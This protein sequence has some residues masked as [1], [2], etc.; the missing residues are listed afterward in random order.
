MRISTNSI[1]DQGV[2]TI[3][4]NQAQMLKTQQQ[5]STGKR[6]LT[7]AD[8]PVGASQLITLTQSDAM[9]TQ[10]QQ[11]RQTASNSLSL[12]DNTLAQVTNILQN[13]RTI[14]VSAGNGTLNDSDRAALAAQLSGDLSELVGLANTGDGLGHYLFSGYQS[15]TQPFTQ[16][17][18]GVQYNGD[19]GQQMIQLDSSSQVAVKTSGANV[20]MN[21]PSGNGSFTTSPAGG[22]SGTGV[23][24][25]G[26]VINS[27]NLTGHKYAINFTAP[28]GVTTYNVVDTST[29]SSVQS[30]NYSSG[31]AIR[32]DGMQVTIQGAPAVGDS[33]DVS[34]STN[35]SVFT[36]VQNLIN[37]LNTPTS[38]SGGTTA[39]TNGLNQGLTNLDQALNNVLT[40]RGVVGVKMNMIDTLN[41][42][43]SNLSVQYKQNES[44]LQDVDLNAAISELTQ[45]Q[46][47]LQAA[48]KSFVQ[49]SGLSLFS[50]L[51]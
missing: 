10:F 46:L 20:F 28:G 33:F 41:T 16:A 6:N 11:N 39:L 24:D 42:I 22:N 34:P 1:F 36:T 17:A 27:A 35:Q 49:I 12:Q 25:P 14:T 21:V 23:I 32:F 40:Q 37:V 48:Q 2:N 30:G 44:Q 3:L 4:N 38:V 5:V 13:V 51:T 8:D 7:P 9:N 43:G 29:G 19:N 50:Y 31:G 45:Q 15:Q 47:N 18:A 26:S